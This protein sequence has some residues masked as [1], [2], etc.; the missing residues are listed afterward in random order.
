[1]FLFYKVG[2]RRSDVLTDRKLSS[3]L[4]LMISTLMSKRCS[5]EVTYYRFAV[6]AGVCCV[7]TAH[8]SFQVRRLSPS[9][10]HCEAKFIKLSFKLKKTFT[11]GV[12]G[13]ISSGSDVLT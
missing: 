13:I 3:G 10:N 9:G 4:L 5:A 8:E 2:N 1:M 11:F 6:C 12:C 7:V